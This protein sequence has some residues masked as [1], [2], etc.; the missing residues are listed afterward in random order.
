MDEFAFMEL[1][2]C[3]FFKRLILGYS[4]KGNDTRSIFSPTR[5]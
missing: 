1:E 2:G 4:F 5:S 3:Y